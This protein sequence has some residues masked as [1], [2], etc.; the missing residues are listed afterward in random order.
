VEDPEELVFEPDGF[1]KQTITDRVMESI[2]E[3]LGSSLTTAGD[4]LPDVAR[5][6]LE[7]NTVTAAKLRARAGDL[8]ESMLAEIRDPDCACR[9]RRLLEADVAAPT[10]LE[11]VNRQ[12]RFLV[13]GTYLRVVAD[14]KREI[15]VF[16]A[17]NAAAFLLLL[18]VSFA[19]P[20]ADRH[21]FVPG[22]LLAVATLVCSFLYVFEQDWLLTIVEGSYLGFAYAA[23]LGVAFG[24]LC[25][26]ALNHGRVTTNLV[27]AVLD[28]IGSAMSSLT[29]C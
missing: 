4:A 24:F 1:A 20:G 8:L 2:D 13:H 9:L 29:P 14:L 11:P 27:N 5:E 22:M 26:I 3:K 10:A 17:T 6:L 21:L 19:K 23:W 25:D 15:R 18:V 28:S 12:L 7:R 16:T